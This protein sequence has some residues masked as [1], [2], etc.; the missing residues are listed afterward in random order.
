MPLLNQELEQNYKIFRHF[1]LGWSIYHNIHLVKEQ[2]PSFWTAGSNAQEDI[3]AQKH[4]DEF[5]RKVW[6]LQGC[7]TLDVS[8]N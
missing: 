3:T 8:V 2:L 6:I 5:R 7:F 1:M 4:L